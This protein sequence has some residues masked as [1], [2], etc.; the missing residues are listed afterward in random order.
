MSIATVRAALQTLETS[1]LAAEY[2]AG[3]TRTAGRAYEQLPHQAVNDADLP[4]CLNFVREATADLTNAGEDFYQTTRQYLVWLL[5]LPASEGLSD[6]E[7][8][9]MVEPVIPTFYNYFLARPKLVAVTDVKRMV[10]ASDSGPRQLV[11]ADIAYWGVEFRL[12]VT[13][14]LTRTYAA[15]E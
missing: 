14:R 7:A 13:E 3:R 6:G 4:V 5:L 10:I 11:W 8:E 12:N 15:I 9:S 1:Y 2:A